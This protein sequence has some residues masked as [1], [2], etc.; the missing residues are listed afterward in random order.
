M[1][2]QAQQTTGDANQRLKLAIAMAILK[3][4]RLQKPNDGDPQ[5][6]PSNGSESDAIVWKR[7]VNFSTVYIARVRVWVISL[8]D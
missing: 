5:P 8:I 3:Y 1:D 6:P 4:K 7:K 2:T